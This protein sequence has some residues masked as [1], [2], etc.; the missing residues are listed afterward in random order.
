MLQELAK[1]YI[2]KSKKLQDNNNVTNLVAQYK[3][4]LKLNNKEL[5]VEVYGSNQ[6]LNDKQIFIKISK[7]ISDKEIYG[8]L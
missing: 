7:E 2:K 6:E 1:G 3:G 4:N 5:V 8:M